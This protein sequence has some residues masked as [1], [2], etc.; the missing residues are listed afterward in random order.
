MIGHLILTTSNGQCGIISSSSEVD[1]IGCILPIDL[2]L[3]VTYRTFTSILTTTTI[4]IITNS[5]LVTVSTIE[6]ICNV[7]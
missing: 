5:V 4:I 1:F 6:I 7:W 2:S 3:S